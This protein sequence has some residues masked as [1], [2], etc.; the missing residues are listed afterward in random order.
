MEYLQL[1]KTVRVTNPSNVLVQIPGMIVAEWGLAK[2]SHLEVF[3]DGEDIRI[4]PAIPTRGGLLSSCFE[5][6]ETV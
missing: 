3:F 2:D 6:A 1:L 4:R 5:D